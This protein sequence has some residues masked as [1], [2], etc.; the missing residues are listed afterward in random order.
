M[1][2]SIGSLNS[3]TN[4]LNFG[5]LATGIDSSSIISGLTQI[6][7]Q[8]ISQLKS[9]QSTIQTAQSAYTAL[10][11]Q[12]YSLQTATSTLAQ[13][14]AG[15]LD[16]RTATSSDTTVLAA[17]AGAS[18]IPGTYALTVNT[19]AQGQQTASQGFSDPN[20]QLKT[21]TMTIQV[22]SGTATTVTLNNQ[23]NTLQGLADAINN[24]GGD[25]RA[26]IVNDGTANPYRLMLTSAKTG[27]ANTIQVTDN[28]TGGSGSDINPLAS[29]IQTA[30]DA[31]VTLGSGP[32]A[33]TVSSA[34]NQV[35]GLVPNVSLSLL[36]GSAGKS[37]SLT[38]GVDTNAATTAVQNLV[39][40]FNAVVDGI[41]NQ[42]K[43]DSTSQTGGV[44]LSSPDA[45]DIKDAL[46]AALT[47]GVPG[48]TGPGSQLSTAGLSFTDS[49]DLQ[50]DTSKLSAVLNGTD[51]TATVADLKTLFGIT[52]SAPSG[53]GVSFLL[54][55]D[56][57]QPSVGSPYGV[58][59]TSPATR[60]TVSSATAPATTI[61]AQSPADALVLK[62][63][64]LTSTGITIPAGDYTTAALVSTLQQQ[65]NSN[66]A[67]NGNQVAVGVDDQG[68]LTITSQVYGQSSALSF[69]GTGSLLTQL[70]FTG[71]E[72][73]DGAD[74]EG[75]FTVGGKTEAAIGTGQILSGLGGN[76]NT[77]GLEVKVTASTPVTST[78]SVTKGIAGNLSSILDQYLDPVNGRMASINSG[79]Q[80]QINDIQKT[81]DTDNT[82][83]SDKTAE[84]QSEF[85]DMETAVSNLKGLQAQLS[86]F[87]P[88][89]STAK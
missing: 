36:P 71:S 76:A 80:T 59:I 46:T 57:T 38:V 13:S 72:V 48:V 23:N 81:I 61:T 70:G 2:L 31:S 45:A 79:Y 4:G 32:G 22:G 5:G 8:Q 14:V 53:S 6:D 41:S 74:V 86:S 85:A 9:Q 55:S 47:N 27:A 52:G 30:A 12:M 16:A 62:V 68:H 40:D 37:A 7:N 35:T 18:A 78:V 67:L 63:N 28:L 54:G 49:G 10:Q 60:A 17:A 43:F 1:S 56:K 26:S 29:T 15:A 21:G 3:N 58:T 89:S 77:A 84:L 39:T 42:S 34:T 82:A 69:S 33:I 50:L 73:G 51:P 83:L 25:V 88:A 24:A 44:F 64:G 11:A 75:S 87:V 20:A 66:T 65:I 19:L